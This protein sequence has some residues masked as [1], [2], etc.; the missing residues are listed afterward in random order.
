MLYAHAMLLSIHSIDHR[1]AALFEG[2][3]PKPNVASQ[4]IAPR[5]IRKRN[6]DPEG[7]AW[8]PIEDSLL[9]QA[10]ERYPTNWQIV[11]DAFNSSRVTIST[12]KRTAWEC[13]ERWKE[14]GKEN[15]AV[16]GSSRNGDMPEESASASS[17]PSYM[18]TRGHKR[19][20]NQISTGPSNG[21]GSAAAAGEPRKRRR[22]AAMYDT[23]R[24][25]AKKR[26]MM[27]KNSGAS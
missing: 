21:S 23:L 5:D 18:A 10:V 11:A 12:D 3:T 27:Q 19:T 1:F 17:A 15:K 9:K 14:I 24:K 26:E 16:A 6:T 4:P 2:A 13:A 20:L 8:T 25:S 22:H 7:I